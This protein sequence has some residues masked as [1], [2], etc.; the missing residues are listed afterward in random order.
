M[1]FN[2]NLFLVLCLCSMV[3]LLSS[4]SLASSI[5]AVSEGVN[6]AK[7]TTYH[8]IYE[9]EI[10]LENGQWQGQPFSKGGASRPAAGL[11]K[12]FSFSGDLDADGME[13][14]IVFLWKSS[15]G[16]GTRVYMAVLAS[17]ENKLLNTETILLGDRIQL[18]MGRVIDGQIELD[19]IQAEEDDAACC[20]THKVLRSWVFKD[21]QLMENKP[22]PL[23][24]ISLLDLEGVNWVLTQLNWNEKV[25]EEAGVTLTFNADK[26]AGRSGCNRYFSTVKSS[27]SAGEIQISQAG[28]TR[29]ACPG[30]AMTLESRYLKALSMVSKYSFVNGQLALTW[31]DDDAT[32]TMLFSARKLK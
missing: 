18:Q 12:G 10:K 5:A 11:I 32:S 14:R 15:G 31:K 6:E 4:V 21:N 1:K 16:S 29:M 28:G 22:Q 23:G 20:P 13:E 25:S 24:V 7:N 2:N 27:G 19:V 9:K 3:L 17:H 8:G 26:V 30:E